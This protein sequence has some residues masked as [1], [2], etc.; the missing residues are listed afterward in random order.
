MKPRTSKLARFV[1]SLAVAIGLSATLVA[2]AAAIGTAGQWVAV[3]G[4]PGGTLTSIVLSPIY[5]AD[6]TV[7]VSTLSAGVFRSSDGGA[8][9]TRLSTGLSN[10]AVNEIALSP[11]LWTDGTI[12]AATTTG[13]FKTTNSGLSWSVAGTGL[14][15][16]DVTSIALS[17]QFDTDS[18]VYAA[19]K[20]SGIYRSLDG[21][22]TWTR[23]G[24]EGMDNL[25][26]IGVRVSP[27]VSTEVF[28]WTATKIFRSTNSGT[29]WATTITGLPI[30]TTVEF[31]NV[32]IAPDYGASKRLFLGTVSDGIYSSTD[33]GSTWMT[34]GLT[35]S[36]RIQGAA[37]SPNFGRDNTLFATSETGGVFIS[38]DRGSNW[39]AVNTSLV[40]LNFGQVAVSHNYVGDRTLFTTSNTG[41][42]YKST[43]AGAGWSNVGNGVS[44]ADV[45]GIGFSSAYATD[46][47]MIG[48]T[49]S[50][51]FRSTDG[52]ATWTAMTTNLP[53]T[54]IGPF[55]A[56]PGYPADGT[57]LVMLTGTGIYRT[58]SNGL[59]WESQNAGTTPI[60]R[61]IPRTIVFSPNHAS[62]FLVLVGGGSGAFRSIDGGATWSDANSGITYTDV[63][64]FGFSPAFAADGTV[65][66]GTAGG[67]VFKSVNGGESWT[68]SNS[69]ITDGTIN[70]VAVSSSFATDRTLLVGTAGG[71]FK[72][73]DGGATWKG[74]QSG[75]FVGLALSPEFGSDRYAFAITGGPG[76]QVFGSSDGGE[77]WSALGPSLDSDMP[78]TIAV[79]P[80]Y[81]SDRNVFVGTSNYGLWV[82]QGTP[83]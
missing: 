47:T 42:L 66:A 10:L 23:P 14:A 73:T 6:S 46:A 9:F 7:F 74:T 76:G 59:W 48:A 65:F 1:A 22:A 33:S 43:D 27:A 83:S 3:G 28:A 50:G 11:K 82:Y 32:D 39:T 81:R 79:S 19:V 60:L 71:I 31:L 68:P 13:V 2:P 51:V 67:S 54:N 61:A 8:T 63:A 70:A 49:K 40:G 75:N 77:T 58:F 29:T 5:F 55:A 20:G 44:S 57:A 69:G 25:D 80:N 30:G 56:S 35:T 21:G 16:G 36:G 37:Y 62:D 34:A 26:V 53:N 52:G 4:P 78:T 18:T 41:L 72:S 12:F 15:S 64:S 24:F 38:T 17:T 45:A